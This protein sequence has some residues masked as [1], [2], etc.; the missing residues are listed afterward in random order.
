MHEA[1]RL[2]T[3]EELERMPE[4]RG[5]LVEG[6]LVEV[7]PPNFEH[8]AVV[9]RLASLLH[10]CTRLKALGTIV[11]ETG[12]KLASNPDTVRGPDIAFVSQERLATMRRRGFVNGPPD[13]AIEVLLPDD[14]PGEI[15]KK[16]GE[17]LTR[18]ASLVVIVDPD[19]KAVDV[20]R[21]G[22]SVT[23]LMNLDDVLDLDDV[24]S[25]CRCTLKQI[26]E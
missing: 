23:T 8:G 18:G 26:F 25:G 21:R 3:A 24:I 9:V 10:T 12:F 20:H 19:E 14:R 1:T 17:Y 5:E 16:I 6:R 11:V 22:G 4:F 7:S 15:R 13:L 2:V